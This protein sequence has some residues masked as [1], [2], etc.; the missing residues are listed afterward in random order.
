MKIGFKK[1]LGVRTQV[2]IQADRVMDIVQWVAQQE[3]KLIG[4]LLPQVSVSYHMACIALSGVC[5]VQSV[6]IPWH[7]LTKSANRASREHVIR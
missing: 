3:G 4:G 1:N 5:S 7:K 2:Q 6:Q